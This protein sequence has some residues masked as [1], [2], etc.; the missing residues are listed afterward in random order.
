MGIAMIN[1]WIASFVVA[2]GVGTGIALAEAD[3]PDYYRVV[4]VD[5]GDV[6]NIRLE[7]NASASKTGAIPP[8]TDG[9]RNLGCVGGLSFE[10]WQAATPAEREAAARDRWCRIEYGGVEG[11][12]AARFLAEG[13]GG[14]PGQWA[15]TGVDP[16]DVLNMRAEPSGNAAIIGA[17][18]PYETG[19]ENL[20][21]TVPSSSSTEW[22]RIRIRD[23]EGW[24]AGRFLTRQ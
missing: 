1:R 9:V 16:G 17:L 10:Q 15:V 21:C 3:G 5:P 19:I 4:G 13:S 20:G 18:A 22:C 23:F 12:V 2:T 6:L 8:D 24:V 14:G 11:W 7:P